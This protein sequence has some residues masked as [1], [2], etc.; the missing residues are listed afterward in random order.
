MLKKSQMSVFD[1]CIR[2]QKEQT[3]VQDV[4]P[5]SVIKSEYFADPQK[6]DNLKDSIDG[7]LQKSSRQT[8]VLSIKKVIK[9][10]ESFIRLYHSDDTVNAFATISAISSF[11][12]LAML[13]ESLLPSEDNVVYF[14][15][16]EWWKYNL[17]KKTFRTGI[18]DLL[19]AGFLLKSCGKRTFK[20]HVNPN[21]FSCGD[22]SISSYESETKIKK[23][24]KVVT[25]ESKMKR[26][27]IR[28]DAVDEVASQMFF[29]DG[30][31][32]VVNG[33]YASEDCDGRRFFK[34][35]R[36]KF[37]QALLKIRRK[38]SAKLIAFSIDSYIPK[39]K[40]LTNI[41][42]ADLS[43]DPI[44]SM[45]KSSY[46]RA[47]NDCLN[48][49]LFFCGKEDNRIYMHPDFWCY[50]SRNKIADF[51]NKKFNLKLPIY[52]TK[53]EKKQRYLSKMF[54]ANLCTN[55]CC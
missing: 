49:G 39:N 42:R 26:Y 28:K 51:I 21:I 8:G 3:K 32:N 40:H 19:L 44:F 41:S 30:S 55:S 31:E 17:T 18:K 22:V 12:V 1:D 4:I 10:R 23:Y 9:D 50:G 38:V 47:V 36:D 27:G 16:S 14:D 45:S 52:W 37:A 48:S 11:K 5:T 13:V 25:D 46:Y 34:V 43:N 15:K 54:N 20:Y 24:V 7:S 29:S 53:K 33:V 2:S 6:I 35:Y